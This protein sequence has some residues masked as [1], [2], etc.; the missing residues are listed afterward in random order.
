[1]MSTVRTTFVSDLHG[2]E[3]DLPGGNL[4]ILGGD[5]TARDKVIDWVNFY[6]WV[7]KQPYDKKIYIA[8]NHDKF[9]QQCITSQE[10]KDMGILEDEVAEYL[11][12]SFTTAFG[13]RI[14]G[15]PWTSHFRGVNPQCNAFMVPDSE[16]AEKWA[17]IPEGLDI[18]VTHSPPYG[19]F[20]HIKNRWSVGDRVGSKSLLE[21]VKEVK[22]AFHVFGH[23][24]ENGGQMTVQDSTTFMN[25][26]CMNEYYEADKKIFTL[27]LYAKI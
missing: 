21:K 14:W 4:L 17:A 1:M 19:I 20:D 16:L 6:K 13:L 27:D 3:L 22:P 11:C 12:D 23:I 8:G 15:S 7:E 18:L 2:L 9:L 26:S 5:C 10:A 24:H 25:I